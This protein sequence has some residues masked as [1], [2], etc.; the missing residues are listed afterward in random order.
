[1][2]NKEGSK[3]FIPVLKDFFKINSWWI[4]WVLPIIILTP[5]ILYYTLSLKSPVGMINSSDVGT[6]I[7]FYGSIIGG[8][9]TLIGVIIT[10]E[11]QNENQKTDYKEREKLK[12]EE[13]KIIYKP[14]I[15]ISLVSEDLNIIENNT[16]IFIITLTNC[17]RGELYFK[18]IDIRQF[19]VADAKNN[20]SCLPKCRSTDCLL[21]NESF[22]IFCTY[23]KYI[24]KSKIEKDNDCWTLYYTI[25]YYDLFND[26]EEAPIVYQF[27]V[28]YKIDYKMKKIREAEEFTM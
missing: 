13:Q 5:F 17:G 9:F 26:Q 28:K 3:K 22:R 2:S 12:K 15:N 24:S 18:S 11:K 4:K 23:N 21:P 14:F 6:F 27:S 16:V 10:I 25:K 7:V 20:F 1:M 8:S 19:N